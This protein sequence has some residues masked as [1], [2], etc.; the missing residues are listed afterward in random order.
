[1]PFPAQ[2]VLLARRA[3]TAQSLDPALVCAIVEQESARQASPSR[4]WIAI[5]CPPVERMKLRD[6]AT[7]KKLW[8]TQRKVLAQRRIS[9]IMLTRKSVTSHLPHSVPNKTFDNSLRVSLFLFT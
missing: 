5:S 9:Y 1:M 8:I 4:S 6:T 2:L 3:A 7:P